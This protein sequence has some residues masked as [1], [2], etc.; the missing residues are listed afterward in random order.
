MSGQSYDALLARGTM[1]FEDHNIESAGLEARLLLEAASGLDQAGLIVSGSIDVPTSVE[2]LFEAHL[3]RRLNGEP[4]F[5]ILGYRFFH[6]LRLELSPGT[7][8]PRDDTEC[9][10]DSVVDEVRRR[11]QTKDPLSF[12]DLGTGTGA[13]ALALLSELPDARAVAT[14]VS[15][16]ALRTARSNATQNGLSDRFEAILGSWFSPLEEKF[17]FV[18][19]NP[20]Y[21]ASH[22]VK[23]LDRE[24]RDHDPWIALDGGVDG[25]DAYRVILKKSFNH[26]KENGFLAL[27]IGFDQARDVTRLAKKAGWTNI[28]NHRDLSGND[29]VIV[30]RR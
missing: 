18:V 19:S 7:L 17:D 10:I 6:G 8:E 28:S 30:L 16:D 9:L 2:Q 25:M 15:S 3:Q 13:I 27:E 20:P 26:L 14:D 24:V 23:Q 5:R 4:V 12:A 1:V 21:I 11:G 29:R 22:T